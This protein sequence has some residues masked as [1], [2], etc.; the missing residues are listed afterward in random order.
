LNWQFATDPLRRLLGPRGLLDPSVRFVNIASAIGPLA[1]LLIFNVALYAGM[2]LGAA[3]IVSFAAAAALNYFIKVHAAIAAAGRTRDLRVYVQLLIVSLL[4]LFLRG[5][6][7]AALTQS[8]GLP[9]QLAIIVAIIATFAVTQPG[10]ALCLSATTGEAGIARW[11][12]LVLGLTAYSLLLRLVYLGQ[13]ELLPEETY[14]W[15]Y[16]RHLDIGYLDH[17]PMAAWLIWLGTAAFGDGSFGVRIGAWCCGVVASLFAYRLTRNLFDEP[18]ALAA[19]LLVQVLPFYFLTGML[20]TPDA[21]LVAAWA[22]ALYF[23]ERALIAERSAAWWWAG[24]CLGIGLLSKYTIGLLGLAMLIFVLAD[25][26]ARRWLRRF[27]PYAAAALA[28]AIFS[29]VIIWNAQHEWASFAFQTSRRL[30][31]TPQFALHKLIAS[32]LVLITPTGVCAVALA[33]FSRRGDGTDRS[34]GSDSRRRQRFMQLAVLV[35]LAVFTA[36]SLR[37]EVKF[38]WTGALWLAA[39]PAMAAGMAASGGNVATAVR[40]G[41]ERAWA[42]TLIGV[43]L[44]FGAGLHYLVLGLPGAGYSEKLELLP[45]GWRD[46]GQQVEQRAA[47]VRDRTGAEPLVVGMNRYAIASELAFYSSDRVKSVANTASAHLFGGRGLMYESWFPAESQ[48]GRTLLLVAW[49]RQ[50]LAGPYVESR[51]ERLGPLQQ[52]VLRRDGAVVRHYYYRIA[53]GYRPPPRD[54]ERAAQP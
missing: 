2:R 11:R 46:L 51:V 27:E 10:Y 21:P 14:Y 3:H 35:P 13:I 7:L 16:S 41:L 54:E 36:F 44:L 52:G 38:D 19:L 33:L 40:S 32:A 22:G 37:H 8:G 42:P 47:E 29:P 15:N 1:D 39:V 43:L 50:E 53:Q 45:I 6:V 34:E 24:V 23:L 5:G 17:P 25:A 9:A 20:T 4:A 26:P 12:V 31:E 48:Q 28:L 30:A 18:S 49:D